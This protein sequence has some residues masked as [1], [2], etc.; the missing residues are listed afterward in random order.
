MKKETLRK[1]GLQDDYVP[2]LESVKAI[3]VTA[4]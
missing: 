1:E 2:Y 4:L 3:W